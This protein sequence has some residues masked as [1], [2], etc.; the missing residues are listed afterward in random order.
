MNTSISSLIFFIFFSMV[1]GSCQNPKP[2]GVFEV[3][4]SE[5]AVVS[6][7]ENGIPSD[8]I[9]LFDGT[10]WDHWVHQNS[11]KPVKWTVSNG[12][13]TIIPKSGNIQT[14]E[15][16][17]D[18]QLHIEWKTPEDTTG[19]KGQSRGNSGVFLQKHYELQILDSYRNE[20]YHNGQAGSI[21]K[22][23]VPL[24]NASKPPNQW[25]VYDI[26]YTAPQ[27]RKDKSLK[28]PAYF[29]VFHNG[30]LIQNHVTVHGKTLNSGIPNY[31]A[32]GDLPLSLQDHNNE[33]QFRNIWIR[34]L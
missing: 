17:G 1:S 12:V 14:K 20:T 13:G 26:I 34:R 2:E 9:I 5:P 4:D 31:T 7:S 32:H 24:V 19:L 28:S 23:H 27:F 33:M 15:S 29:T 6:F 25:Q 3:W 30:I 11:D 21:Y 22:Q 16:F 18:C 10:S 8:A